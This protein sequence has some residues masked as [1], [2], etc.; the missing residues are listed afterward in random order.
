MKTNPYF[1]NSL[2]EFVCNFYDTLGTTAPKKC[3][4]PT[5]F[6]LNDDGELVSLSLSL[7]SLSL[8]SSGEGEE[9]GEEKEEEGGVVYKRNLEV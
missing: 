2:T 9:K 4:K 5:S 8:S 7:S 6:H 3:E 1:N